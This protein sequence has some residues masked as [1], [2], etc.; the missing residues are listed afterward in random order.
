MPKLLI[1]LAQ[2]ALKLLPLHNNMQQR[3]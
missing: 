1:I 2:C 3:A